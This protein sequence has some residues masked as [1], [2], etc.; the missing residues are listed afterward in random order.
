MFT[1]SDEY[2]SIVARSVDTL[3]TV[4]QFLYFKTSYKHFVKIEK[5]FGI[6][7]YVISIPVVGKSRE[8]LN[9]EIC[10]LLELNGLK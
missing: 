5:H 9:K 8:K 4:S 1:S 6:T 2:L 10:E 3:E 7:L